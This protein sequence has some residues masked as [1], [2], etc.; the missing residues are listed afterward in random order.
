[1][2]IPDRINIEHV[3]SFCYPHPIP[4][5]YIAVQIKQASLIAADQILWL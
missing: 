5:G 1:M 4:V 2:L 3:Y